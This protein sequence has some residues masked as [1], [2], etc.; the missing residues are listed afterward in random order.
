MV[1]L[2]GLPKT[3]IVKLRVQNAAA[4]LAMNIGKYSHVTQALQDLH[5]LPVRTSIDFKILILVLRLYTDLH[6]HILVI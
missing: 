3:Q 2:Y 6:H 1:F 4:K 5:W